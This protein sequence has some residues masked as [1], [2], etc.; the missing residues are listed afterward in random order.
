MFSGYVWLVANELDNKPKKN[1]IIEENF[2]GHSYSGIILGVG[3]RAG[4]SGNGR[5]CLEKR[6]LNNTTH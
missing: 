6:D 3:V 1:F 2:P 5:C 4:E